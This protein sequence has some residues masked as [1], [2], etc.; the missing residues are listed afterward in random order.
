M[1]KKKILIGILIGLVLSLAIVF[2]MFYF[3]TTLKDAAQIEKLGLT[4]LTSIPEKMEEGGKR[5]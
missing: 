1:K 2:A 5:K 3:D 4:V